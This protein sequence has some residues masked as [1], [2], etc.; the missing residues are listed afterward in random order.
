MTIR[1]NVAVQNKTIFSL[2]DFKNIN[3][4]IVCSEICLLY[5]EAELA[6]WMLLKARLAFDARGKKYLF[7][8]LIY[9]AADW[10]RIFLV[11]RKKLL[12]CRNSAVEQD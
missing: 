4:I 8:S 9:L 11:K 6:H 7:T 5:I 10:L 2:G 3:F 12:R 1:K